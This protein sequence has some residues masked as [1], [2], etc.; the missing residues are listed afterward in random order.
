MD[1]GIIGFGRFGKIFSKHLSSDFKVLVSSRTANIE[2]V[3][4]NGCVL[5]TLEKVCACDLVI[6]CVPISSFEAVIE[7]ISPLLKSGSIV[8]DVCSVKEHPVKIMKNKLPDKIQILASH[9]MFGPDSASESL[10]KKKIVM[11]PIRIS[12]QSYKTIKEYFEKKGLL[13]VETSPEQHDKDIAKTLF[14]THLIGRTLI[15]MQV[16]EIEIGTEGF[17]R[18]FSIIEMVKND[19][20]QLFLDMAYFNKYSH[21]VRKEFEQKMQGISKRLE[22]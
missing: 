11:C 6:P 3:K 1:V 19:S 15:D 8:M 16:K 9:P 7:K 2:D 12:D 4:K 20:E 22:R 21:G 13:I 14:L 17:N 10:N 18:L 5:S